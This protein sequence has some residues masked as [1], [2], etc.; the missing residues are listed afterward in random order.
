MNFI[1]YR[2]LI[3][4]ISV[5]D[6]P[7]ELVVSAY[8]SPRT[9]LDSMSLTPNILNSSFLLDGDATSCIPVHES[10]DRLFQAV[11]ALPILNYTDESV[12]EFEVVTTGESGCG[13]RYWTFF[14]EERCTTGSFRECAITDAHYEDGSSMCRVQCSCPL[15]SCEYLH[16]KYN[17]VAWDTQL[18]TKTICEVRRQY[19]INPLPP[20]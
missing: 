15:W 1:N 7:M 11:F 14:V 9:I 12:A 17:H 19:T 6:N 18:D 16:V 8:S 3:R 2:R 4:V 13:A 10:R 5:S 20:Q